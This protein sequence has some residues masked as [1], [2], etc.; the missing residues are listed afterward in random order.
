VESDHEEV[1]QVQIGLIGTGIMGAP[2]A[3]NLLAAE[4]SLTVHDVRE[5]SA[6]QA[7]DAGA[8]WADTTAAACHGAEVVLMSL[9]TPEA[10]E[11]VALEAIAAMTS[12]SV[13]VD[14]STS[15]PSLMRQLASDAAQGGIEFLDAPVSGGQAGARRGTLSVMVGGDADVLERCRPIFQAIGENIYHVG[16]V[17]SGDVAKL[18]N[19]MLC[20]IH[21]WAAVEGIALGARAGV[22]PNVL[23]DIVST[24]SGNSAVWRGGTAA[25]LRDRLQP[26]FDMKLIAK[27]MG[28]ALDMAREFEVPTAMAHRANTLITE[29]LESGYA[30]SD[31]FG[32]IRAM[33]ARTGAEVRG[34][35]R[36]DDAST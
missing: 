8:K 5:E 7:L 21:M 3:A 34:R 16:A 13:L 6:D 14:H 1:N 28:L 18:V 19:N 31:I 24:S 9:P 22:D 29:Y 32:T 23:R 15:P 36:D 17:G 25:M 26:S 35:W 2:M 20:F 33:E 27:D 11:T 30:D 4:F 10:V 12:G